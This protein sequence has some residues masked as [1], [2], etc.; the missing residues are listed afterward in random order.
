MTDNGSFARG[1]KQ[2][3]YPSWTVGLLGGNEYIICLNF[4]S[5]HVKVSLVSAFTR[6]RKQCVPESPEQALMRYG[7]IMTAL[8]EYL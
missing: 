3:C 1:D 4:F 2:T 5:V 6:Y 8:I 7:P